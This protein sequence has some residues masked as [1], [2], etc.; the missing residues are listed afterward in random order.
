MRT[1]QRFLL[2][3]ACLLTLHSPDGSEL[4]VESGM[5]RAVRAIAPHAAGQVARGARSVIYL[6]SAP[7]GLAVVESTTEIQ[8]RLSA[9]RE[10]GR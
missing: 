5:L 4:L 7:A 2:P 9:C 10:A 6:G 8:D 3:L 1:G